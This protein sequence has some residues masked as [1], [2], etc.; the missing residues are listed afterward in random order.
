MIPR[1]ADG[2]LGEPTPVIKDAH[3][4]G[5]TV[6]GWTFRRENNSCRRSSAPAPDPAAH[7]DLAGELRVFLAAGMDGAFSDQPDI[8]ASVVRERR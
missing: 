5:L 8:A 1:Q 2:T 7:G 4:A 6:H 3:R